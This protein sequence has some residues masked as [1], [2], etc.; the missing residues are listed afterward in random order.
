MKL[1]ITYFAII[2]LMIT[3]AALFYEWNGIWVAEGILVGLGFAVS[4]K[5]QKRRGR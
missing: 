1:K 3:L 5:I 2:V 4:D